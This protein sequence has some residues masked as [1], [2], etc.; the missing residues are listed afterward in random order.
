MLNAGRLEQLGSPETIYHHPATPFVAEFVGAADF[1]PGP[2]D[3]RGHRDRDRRVRPRRGPRA[4]HQGSRDDPSRRRDASCRTRPARRCW[5]QRYFR[6]SENALLPGAALRPP[7]ALLA[8]LLGGL[9]HR[10]ARAARGQRPPRRRVSR[11]SS[12]SPRRRP[13]MTGAWSR[14]TRGGHRPLAHSSHWASRGKCTAMRQQRHEGEG[15]EVQ[16]LARRSGTG[17]ARRSPTARHSARTTT[18]TVNRPR[19]RSRHVG[20]GRA[21]RRAGARSI[22]ARMNR[23][24]TRSAMASTMSTIRSVSRGTW[25]A[26]SPR[27]EPRVARISSTITASTTMEPTSAPPT[28]WA[29]PATLRQVG[30]RSV[31][32][33]A[34]SRPGR[35]SRRS[36]R[37]SR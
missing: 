12:R 31:H 36:M 14:L 28:S 23:M 18:L 9:R 37:A 30:R 33:V 10:P 27:T 20:G 24:A 13:A 8:A 3:R 21:S 2:G 16:P 5:L 15:V 22:C 25:R 32:V 19:A 4:G 34:G 17:R 29:L 35:S 26:R 1:L 7:R 11:P 6:G